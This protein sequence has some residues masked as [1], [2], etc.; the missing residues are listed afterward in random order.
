MSTMRWVEAVPGQTRRHAFTG[1]HWHAGL[2]V[3]C[4]RVRPGARASAVAHS[5]I[6]AGKSVQS[7]PCD[8]H[9]GFACGALGHSEHRVDV[10]CAHCCAAAFPRG[11]A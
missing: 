8:S 5:L 10:S 6:C 3:R 1:W 11:A 4:G 2:L 7:A 9:V